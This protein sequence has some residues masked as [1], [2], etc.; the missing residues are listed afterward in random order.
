M[1]NQVSEWS[2]ITNTK[3]SAQKNIILKNKLLKLQ[4]P[5]FNMRSLAIE[6]EINML[7]A[8]ESSFYIFTRCQNNLSSDTTIC[9]ITKELES[10]RKFISFAILE[11]STVD[12]HLCLKTLKKQ[13]IPK[14]GKHLINP[15]KTMMKILTLRKSN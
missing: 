4:E 8:G 10:S 9:I 12:N 5:N 11:P 7:M 2:Q 14:Q 13:E 15:K 1:I 3:I 6:L